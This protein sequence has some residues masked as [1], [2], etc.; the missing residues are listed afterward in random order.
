MTERPPAEAWTDT[1]T[2]QERVR[3]VVETLR[4]AATAAEIANRADTSQEAAEEELKRLSDL[5]WV[6]ITQREDDPLYEPNPA[7][8]FFDDLLTLIEE[9]SREELEAKRERLEEEARNIPEDADGT[10]ADTRDALHTEF[11]L[12]RHALHLYDDVTTLLE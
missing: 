10:A 2:P 6:H 8:L 3:A 7:Q 4:S 12:V 9:N 11:L 5:N 1:M